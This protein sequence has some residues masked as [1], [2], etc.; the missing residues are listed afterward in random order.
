MKF[1]HDLGS[2]S[3]ADLKSFLRQNLSKKNHILFKEIFDNG[4]DM[5]ISNDGGATKNGVIPIVTYVQSG[6]DM[7]E[8]TEVLGGVEIK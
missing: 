2:P 4:I 7:E 6:D 8:D 5:C 1:L 3:Y